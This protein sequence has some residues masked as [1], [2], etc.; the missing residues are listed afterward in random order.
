MENPIHTP[1]ESPVIEKLNG[2]QP[3]LRFI[4][5]MMLVGSALMLPALKVL[6]QR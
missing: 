4:G 3:W 6:S 2:M 5:I 1:A